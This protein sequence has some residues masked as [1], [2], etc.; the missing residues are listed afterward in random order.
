M[1]ALGLLFMIFL[2]CLLITFTSKFTASNLLLSNAFLGD[3]L[4]TA[5]LIY[6]LAI[7]KSNVSKLTVFRVF[8][9][10]L[11]MAGLV[12][13]LHSNPL[14]QFIKTWISPVIE[15]LVIFIICKKFYAANKKA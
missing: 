1:I 15:A 13:P 8:V 14:L 5:P 12:M 7:R 2:S 3:L 10:G 4:I 11:L 9:A 6:F